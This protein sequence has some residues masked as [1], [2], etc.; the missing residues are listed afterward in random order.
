MCPRIIINSSSLSLIAHRHTHVNI[1]KALLPKLWKILKTGGGG[2]AETI[3]PHLLPLLSKLNKGILGEK[4]TQFYSNFFENTNIGLS[5]RIIHPT[6]SRA[7]VT[8]IATAYYECLQFVVIQLRCNNVFGTA[9]ELTDYCIQLAQAHI[10]DVIG[11]LLN[12]SAAHNGKFVLARM[13]LLV[14]FWGQN[15]TENQLYAALVQHFWSNVYSVVD[16]S[17]AT[18]DND[19]G[20]RLELTL[21]L[22]QCLRSRPSHKPKGAKVKFNLDET[23]DEVDC[24]RVEAESNVAIDAQLPDFVLQLSKMYVKKIS[25]TTNS[26]FIDHLENLLKIFGNVD[27]YRQLVDGGSITKLYDKFACWLLI[28]HLRQENVVDLILMLY[29]HLNAEER[30]ALLTKL[31]KFPNSMVQNWILSRILSHPL[32]VDPD[33]VQFIG[34]QSVIELLVKAAKAV[35]DGSS[36]NINLLHKC[37]F[38]NESGD[39]LIDC[40]TCEQIANILLEPLSAEEPNEEVLDTCASFLAQI[41]PVVCGDGQKKSIQKNLF[42]SLFALSCHKV[43]SERYAALVAQH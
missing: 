3:Y 13:I 18:V 42:L 37:F 16:K 15:V 36:E 19:T 14:Q 12:S 9:E 29:P 32:C 40:N 4:T 6:S 31:V 21:E 27:F 26:A 23:T 8:A 1:E 22:V 33:V 38:Q 10:I 17:F 34:Q 5:S 43:V 25:D 41:V 35:T 28:G 2:S 7:E 24:V 39:I 11:L 30:I 20:K